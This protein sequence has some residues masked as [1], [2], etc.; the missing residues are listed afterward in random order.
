MPGPRVLAIL[1]SFFPSAMITVVKPLLRL[2][3]LRQV[4]LD[5]WHERLV[6]ER[7][8]AWADVVVFCRNVK[9]SYGRA[10]E[11]AREHN[12]A[13][14]YEFDD[15]LLEVPESAPDSPTYA[16]PRR[17]SQIRKYL[18]QADLVRVYSAALLTYVADYTPHV[19]RVDGPV[20]WS[21]V[22]PDLP[23]QDP[24]CVRLVYAT[25]R[26]E[27]HIGQMVVPDVQQILETYPQVEVVVWGPR[28]RNLEEHP[29]VRHFPLV[30]DYDAFFHAFARQGFD[31]GLA[32]LPMGLFYNCKSNNKFREYAACGITGIYSDSEVYRECVVDGDTGLLVGEESGAWFRAIARLVED[33]HL[34]DRIRRQARAYA[35]QHYSM[36]K[37][38][39]DWMRDLEWVLSRRESAPHLV[40]LARAAAVRAPSPQA[41]RT[42][43]GKA[44]FASRAA[45]K[46]MSLARKRDWALTAGYL[47]LHYGSFRQLVSIK[48]RLWLLRVRHRG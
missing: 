34:R 8:V 3:E 7:S 19:V 47:K 21:L 6:G 17:R 40:A 24:R 45:A 9:A 27:D 36:E 38:Q 26:L 48:T 11:W 31:I 20:D 35:R 5:V 13:V 18:R 33:P 12:K 42:S 44:Q 4:E 15:N 37:M 10:L 14:V 2:H 16:T 23:L 29:R 25:S 46:A 30:P 28:L 1:P 43:T 41:P 22:P 39:A 32:P